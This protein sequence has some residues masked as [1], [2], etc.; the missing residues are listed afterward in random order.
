[1]RPVEV[2]GAAV[3]A[4]VSVI[5]QMLPPI[6]L[7]PWFMRIDLV[8]VPW[9]L[10]WILF[11]FRASLL[12]LAI[13]IPIVGVLGPFAGG[14]V[15]AVMKAMASIWMIVVPACFALRY[16]VGRMLSSRLLYGVSALTAILVRGVATVFLNLYFA[17]PIFFGMTLPQII[18]FFSK[19]AFQSF[20]GL[21]LGLIGIWAA[22]G[23][24][25]FWNAVQG[26]ID[27]YLSLAIGLAVIRRL[28]GKP[29]QTTL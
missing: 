5:L 25:F 2:A 26:V 29:S 11:G 17:I 22:V 27:L 21:S 20:F 28:K 8:A 12:S 24:I 4:A 18:E 3:L 13:S 15:G 23:E 14:W 9:I 19:P 6:F 10:A 7:T 16:G 1:M